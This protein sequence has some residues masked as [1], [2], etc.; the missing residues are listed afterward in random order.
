MFGTTQE[1]LLFVW[2]TCVQGSNTSYR[3]NVVVYITRT[4]DVT[5]TSHAHEIYN[6]RFT[7]HTLCLFISTWY[8]VIDSVAQEVL[9][10]RFMRSLTYIKSKHSESISNYMNTNTPN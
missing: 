7:L 6:S 1:G 3:Q 4:T 8:M 10:N 5:S 2:K 9:D